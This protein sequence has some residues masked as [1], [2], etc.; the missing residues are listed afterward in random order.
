MRL[1]LRH[2]RERRPRTAPEPAVAVSDPAA[3]GARSGRLGTDPSPLGRFERAA[4][5]F[6]ASEAGR[7]VTGLMRTLGDPQVSVGACAGA[8]DE[9][10]ITVAWELSWYQWGVD[11]GDE[12][13]PVFVL[14]KGNEV[15][16]IDAAARQWN[17]AVVDGGRVVLAAPTAARASKPARR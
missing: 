5:R 15:G 6:N 8:A 3:R 10:R 16:Q 2:G 14:A 17:A 4:A 11:L 1:R 9:V 7:T 13:R 12:R